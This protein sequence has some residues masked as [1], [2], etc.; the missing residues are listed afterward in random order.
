MES[1]FMPNFC[2]MLAFLL[3][4]TCM[5][6]A[7]ITASAQEQ[8]KEQGPQM[9][10]D[11]R[12]AIDKINKASGPEAK[13]KAS[14]DYLKKFGKSPTRSKVANYVAE[15][16]YRVQDNNQKIKFAQEFS[17]VFNQPGEAD[18][19]KPAL[20]EA[21]VANSKFDEAI[22]ESNK[23][24]EKNPDDVTIYIQ[25]AW[26]GAMQVQKDPQHPNQKLTQAALQAGAKAVELMEADKRPARMDDK[27]W[28]DYRNSWLWRL[29]QARGVLLVVS[30]D[31]VAAKESF[32]KAIGIESY[33]PSILLQLVNLSND[34][35]QALAQQY[36]KEQKPELMTKA[37]EKMDEVIDWYARA[38]AVTEGNAQ[39]KELNGQ[40][41]EN[42]KQYYSFR[43]N[44][45]TDGLTGLIEKYKK[46]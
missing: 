31:K 27:A 23:Y 30:N 40:L 21:Y 19:V 7:T 44:G 15:E 33:E 8:K 11:E 13:L 20:I 29:Y 1:K 38:V 34:E 3:A 14:G 24:L 36:Q 28:A 16:V 32:E 43:N 18:L 39:L 2:G 42:L 46:K 10:A 17:S 25:I 22:S 45:K 35:Y 4:L 37:L 26:A 6:A 5:G 12:T 9:S 41:M